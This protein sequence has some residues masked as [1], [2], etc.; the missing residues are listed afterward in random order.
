VKRNTVTAFVSVVGSRVA[1][2]VVSIFIT[3]L[4]F[5][6]LGSGTYGKWGTVMAVFSL[7]MIFIS[8][9]IGGGA[10][11]FL[12]ENRP[13]P[14]WEDHVFAYYFRLAG[15][16][17]LVAAALLVLAAWS[18]FVTD[19]LGPDYASY[20]YILAVLTVVAQYRAYTRLS[21]MG[22]K[23]EHLSEPIRVSRKVVFGVVAVSLAWLGWGVKGV[24][25][26]EIVAS[27]VV[28][29]LSTAFVMRHVSLSAIVKPLPS[30]FPRWELFAFNHN[31]IAYHFLMTSLIHVDVLMLGYFL[32]NSDTVGIY[33]GA[34]VI[35]QLL[36]I[37]PR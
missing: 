4:L 29:V 21:L 10:R 35:V 24:L 37:L 7:L 14:N 36:W 23:L 18:G 34:L 22:L 9:G 3:P 26:G 30:D 28:I 15:A 32:T 5:R 20:F 12:S 11:K 6:F 19:A 2:L 31:S 25:Y 16:L 1:I 33:K 13:D 8:A 27:A 17:A